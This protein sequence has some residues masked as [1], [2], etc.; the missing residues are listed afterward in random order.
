MVRG[1]VEIQ[2]EQQYAGPVHR[3]DPHSATTSAATVHAALVGDELGAESLAG[4]LIAS[5]VAEVARRGVLE[6]A[7]LNAL[8]AVDQNACPVAEDRYAVLAGV[9]RCALPGDRSASP[10]A[11]PNEWLEV[12]APCSVADQSGCFE[13]TALNAEGVH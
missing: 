9:G 4:E 10:E 5:P 3:S 13:V 1:K 2:V 12:V 8:M 6:A 7:G 11:V